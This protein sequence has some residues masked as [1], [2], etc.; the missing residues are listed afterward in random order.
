MSIL[1]YQF[2]GSPSF[3]IDDQSV[4]LNR[5]KAIA[6]AAYITIHGKPVP[7][8]RLADLFWPDY[9]R[10]KALASLRRTLS[11]MCKILG[12]FWVKADRDAVCFIPNKNIYVDVIQFQA[13]V[14]RYTPDPEALELATQIYNGPFLSGFYLEDAPE[15]N[16]WQFVRKEEFERNFMGVLESITETYENMG[17]T[18]KAIKHASVWA[19]LDPLNE[20]AH[21]CLIRLHGY[22]GQKSMAHRQY[23]RCKQILDSELGIPPDME[24]S[25]LAHQILRPDKAVAEKINTPQC[26][27]PAKSGSFIGRQREL[28]EITSRLCQESTRLLTLTGPGGIGK[29]WLAVE[30]IDKL[31]DSLSMDVFFLPLANTLSIDAMMV[32]LSEILG[33]RPDNNQELKKQVLAFLGPRKILL[34]MD[35]L[36]HLSGIRGT[37]FQMLDQTEHL[38]ILATSRSRLT[39]KKEHVIPLSGLGYHPNDPGDDPVQRIINTEGAALFLSEIRKVRPDFNPNENNV[40]DIIR[41]CRLTSGIPLALVLA[42]GRGDVFSLRDIADQISANIDFLQ[43]KH[44]DVASC[45]RSMRAVFDSSWNS[46]TPEER[47]VFIRLSVFKGQFTRQAADAVAQSSR[48]ESGDCALSGLIR[49]SL[50]KINS[51]SGCFEIHSLLAQYAG[52][53]LLASGMMEEILDKHENYYLNLLRTGEKELIGQGMM[54]YRTDMDLAF[55]NIEHAWFRAVNRGDIATVSRSATGLYIYFDMH[56]HYLNGERFFRAAKQSI[57]SPN[58]SFRPEF[59]LLLLC[60][61]DMQ[62]QSSGILGSAGEIQ[63][64][65]QNWLRWAVKSGCSLSRAHALLFMGAIAQ[66]KKKYARAIRLYRLSLSREPKV[67]HAFWVTN[68]IGLCLRLQNM[69]DQALISFE[70][71]LRIGQ[72]LGDTVKIAWSL[73]NFGSAHLCLGNLDSAVPLLLSAKDIFE[74]IKASMGVISCLEEL[75]LIA[76]FQGALDRA[77]ELAGQ[78][79]DLV[80]NTGLYLY[81][82]QRATALKGLAL[83]MTGNPDQGQTYFQKIEKTGPPGFTACMGMSFISVFNQNSSSAAFYERKASNFAGSVNKPQLIAL[84]NLLQAAVFSLKGEK[85][86]AAEKLDRA[87]KHPLRPRALFDTWEFVR[88]LVS[89]IRSY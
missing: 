29:T 39:L 78:A 31:Q 56:T 86:A 20:S 16:D 64:F 13:L 12:N 21:R 80:E 34:F 44:I 61:F 27:K 11:S 4:K 62:N 43:S 32:S 10:Q 3:F 38:K 83:I 68:R 52:D 76:L 42:G 15:F 63:S 8:E 25:K 66:R 81:S 45:H 46:L 88:E 84:L 79:I 58:S 22:S 35:N 60:W 41:I 23:E 65:V 33:L 82:Y 7:R 6:L 75:S 28:K 19:E 1:T 5:R 48:K 69:M 37:I 54:A 85:T 17:N 89:Q 18:A 49:K 55:A 70:K 77:A 59:G 51:D 74:N 72:D 9:G 26:P 53:K 40:N 71:S 73:G 14:S 36:E 50:V 47:D 67:E 24:T 2:F 87:I 30:A 57:S